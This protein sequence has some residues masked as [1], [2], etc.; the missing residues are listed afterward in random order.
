MGC[1]SRP[2]GC[3][4]KPPRLR[5]AF[6]RL[7]QRCQNTGAAHVSIVPENRAGFLEF[8]AAQRAFKGLD[9]IPSPG[10]GDDA[11]GFGGSLF[12]KPGD[13]LCRQTWHLTVELVFESAV[14]IHEANFF[15]VL[16]L[17]KCLKIRESPAVDAALRAP[18]SGSRSIPEKT[19]T[20]EHAGIIVQIESGGADLDGNRG[21]QCIGI[22]G[23]IAARRFQKGERGSASET[24]KI[25]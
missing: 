24:Q 22:G 7:L 11:V 21:D 8:V 6:D 9:H 20:H 10:M 15:A 5:M 25:L 14:G 19:Q 13:R 23:E 3:E 16:R 2:E 1:E 18:E 12:K 4:P 17:V